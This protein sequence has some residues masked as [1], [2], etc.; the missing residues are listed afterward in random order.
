MIVLKK[1]NTSISCY[2]QLN[3]V[4]I[5]DMPKHTAK[6]WLYF[7]ISVNENQYLEKIFNIY[8]GKIIN[9]RRKI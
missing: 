2:Q 9:D 5:S 8:G 4:F 3:N 7:S 6:L 1:K